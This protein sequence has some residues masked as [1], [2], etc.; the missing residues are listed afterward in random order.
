MTSFPQSLSIFSFGRVVS[1]F[2]AALSI[3]LVLISMVPRGV[4]AQGGLPLETTVDALKVEAEIA[5]DGRFMAYGFGSLWMMSGPRLAR[6]NADDNRV[7]DVTLKD[8]GGPNRGVAIGEGA[9]WVPDVGS[10]R[11]YAVDPI[12]NQQVKVIPAKMGSA[13]G[14]IAVGFGSLWVVTE[15]KGDRTLVRFN[16]QTGDPASKIA[17]P[18]SAIGVLIDYGSVWVTGDTKNQLY[19]IDPAS[20]FIVATVPMSSQPRFLASGEGSIWVYNQGDGNVQRVDPSTNKVVATIDTGRP[21]GGGS[22]AVGGGYV[23]LSMLHGTPVV[24]IDAKT[25]R[26]IHNFRGYGADAGW[27]DAICFGDGSVWVSGSKLH[28]IKPAT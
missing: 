23:W 4:Q 19:R 5:R 24:Q 12:S 17:L 25:N 26:L 3:A 28:R 11:I 16:A 1:R 9:V 14:S 18:S 10:D 13:E 22:I 21:G 15:E 7:T 8:Y 6:I 20:N 2:G 27:G